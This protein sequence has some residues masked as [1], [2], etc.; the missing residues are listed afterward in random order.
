MLLVLRCAAAGRYCCRCCCCC[1]WG[2]LHRIAAACA[3]DTGFVSG[4]GEF[5][6]IA[7]G[8][9]CEHG[10]HKDVISVLS[11]ISPPKKSVGE[12]G[13]K[14]ITLSANVDSITASSGELNHLSI[15]LIFTTGRLLFNS[16]NNLNFK[17][18]SEIIKEN[19]KL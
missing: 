17:A 7:L 19:V 13:F 16:L 1:S 8:I 11:S 6:L 3:S 4:N 2:L 10:Q 15:F 5:T 12:D 14:Y 18:W 9:I